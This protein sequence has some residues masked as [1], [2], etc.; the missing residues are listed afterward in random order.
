MIPKGTHDHIVEYIRLGS[1]SK[2]KS[3]CLH[4]SPFVLKQGRRKIRFQSCSCRLYLDCWQVS[5]SSNSSTPSPSPTPWR[6]TWKRKLY[7]FDWQLDASILQDRASSES[8]IPILYCVCVLCINIISLPPRLLSTIDVPAFFPQSPPL[9]PL[10][11]Y[12]FLS[13]SMS[14]SHGSPALSLSLSLRKLINLG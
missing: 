2:N 11:L 6:V 13:L 7:A 4:Q 10:P 1:M 8:R 3:W 14:L 9:P 5:S 12:V